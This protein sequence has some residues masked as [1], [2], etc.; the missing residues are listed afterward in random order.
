MESR[1]PVEHDT[2]APQESTRV[3]RRPLGDFTDAPLPPPWSADGEL[4]PITH[5]IIRAQS[6][7]DRPLQNDGID[8]ARELPASR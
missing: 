1:V 2:Q 4:R 3:G 8:P 7:A 6:L 5:R